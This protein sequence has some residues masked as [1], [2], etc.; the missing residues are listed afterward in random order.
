[1]NVASGLE[2]VHNTCLWA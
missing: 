1:M 2:K